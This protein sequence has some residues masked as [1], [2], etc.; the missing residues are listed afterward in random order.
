MNQQ[1]YERFWKKQ[2]ERRLKTAELD[3]EYSREVRTRS[4]RRDA[5]LEFEQLMLAVVTSD[6]KKL[7]KAIQ[8]GAYVNG[9]N[10]RS[11]PVHGIN[12]PKT[13]LTL[14]ARY[15]NNPNNENIIKIL[16]NAGADLNL[17]DGPG[18]TPIDAAARNNNVPM[19]MLLLNSG[20]P[21]TL[22]SYKRNAIFDAI[23][24]N[25]FEVFQILLFNA[26][27]DDLEDN[28]STNDLSTIDKSFRSKDIRYIKALLESGLISIEAVRKRLK[29]YPYG[30]SSEVGM[31]ICSIGGPGVFDELGPGLLHQTRSPKALL[32]YVKNGV[33]INAKKEGET[34]LFRYARE[35]WME[36]NVIMG[37]L[38]IAI[39]ADIEITNRFGRKAFDDCERPECL[40]MLD[41]SFQLRTLYNALKRDII[42]IC[43]GLQTLDF[44]VMI[45]LQIV[46][47]RLEPFGLLLPFHYLFYLIKEVKNFNTS[48]QD[49]RPFDLRRYRRPASETIVIDSPAYNADISDESDEPEPVENRRK[50]ARIATAL[51]NLD[52]AV[53][54]PPFFAE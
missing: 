28:I 17:T 22:R 20:V 19:A 52:S 53:D 2:E 26:T 32:Y 46:N 14:A 49:L 41:K 4:T 37:A 29:D 23:M 51:E 48:L 36:E 25:A 11:E 27:S 43:L 30:T 44:P 13:P 15:K 33:D 16:I 7:I 42:E 10:G 5:S 9:I 40:Q 3:A 39:G 31:Y 34:I 1:E 45:T 35:W 50:R 8:N 21:I 24:E 12:D 38:A 47:E 18:L 6:E 54:N